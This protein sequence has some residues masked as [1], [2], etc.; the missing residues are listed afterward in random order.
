MNAGAVNRF[1]LSII[2]E[3]CSYHHEIKRTSRKDKWAYGSKK[4]D[5]LSHIE[6]NAAVL[7][8]DGK[9]NIDLIFHRIIYV[10]TL[11]TFVSCYGTLWPAYLYWVLSGFGKFAQSSFVWTFSIFR[12]NAVNF[13]RVIEKGLKGIMK[14]H[15]SFDK[16]KTVKKSTSGLQ[17]F[18]LC[19]MSI[20]TLIV[21]N[22]T[23]INMHN[24][25]DF[26]NESLVSKFWMANEI[27]KLYFQEYKDL[28]NFN[29]GHF[30]QLWTISEVIQSFEHIV[31]H[32]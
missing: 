9:M 5:N 29:T 15:A 20:H 32:S 11:M 23:W 6:L 22:S 13:N 1:Y 7:C 2:Y 3:W 12:H 31:H 27:T 26:L 24:V 28:L 21:R 8:N 18:R 14:G 19:R 10:S 25:K 30:Y 16:F 17:L 4:K